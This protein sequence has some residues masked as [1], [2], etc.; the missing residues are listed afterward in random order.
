MRGRAFLMAKRKNEQHRV[1]KR[2]EMILFL[3]VVSSK[4][5]R[6]REQQQQLSNPSNDINSIQHKNHC[7]ERQS[8]LL[9]EQ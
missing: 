9:V 1:E 2:N 7:S 8:F 6:W 5:C 4:L 3:K